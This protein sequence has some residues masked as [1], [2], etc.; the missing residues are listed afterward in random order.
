VTLTKITTENTLFS[1]CRKV[2]TSRCEKEK[3]KSKTS[4]KELT[5]ES[6]SYHSRIHY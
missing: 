2:G 5:K 4:R 6:G 3:V 1:M